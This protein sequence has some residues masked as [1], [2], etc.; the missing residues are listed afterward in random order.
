MRANDRGLLA[1]GCED[2]QCDFYEV[3]EADQEGV[4]RC[5]CPEGCDMVSSFR[6]FS[7]FLFCFFLGGK[8]GRV[9]GDG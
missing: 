7:F 6:V 5:V 9:D 4:G 8:G 2:K 1:G 3:C